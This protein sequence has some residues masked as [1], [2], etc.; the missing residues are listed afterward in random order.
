MRNN[1]K[2]YFL[3]LSYVSLIMVYWVENWMGYKT[4]PDRVIPFLNK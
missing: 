2:Y 3:L 1:K 4:Y